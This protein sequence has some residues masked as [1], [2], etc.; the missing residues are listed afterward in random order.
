MSALGDFDS[1]SSH[2]Q[3]Q[4]KHCSLSH[5]STYLKVAQHYAAEVRNQNPANL[6]SRPY[7][8]WVLAK[9]R[10]QQSKKP[11]AG[12]LALLEHLRKL[13]GETIWRYGMFPFRHLTV[14]VP[15]ADEA[16]DWK[17]E[18]FVSEE[19][20]E[21]TRMVHRVATELGDIQLQAACLQLMIYSAS[22]PN[23]HLDALGNLWLSVGNHDG[24][25]RSKLYCYILKGS[26]AAR[27]K[28]FH[29]ILCAREPWDAELLEIQLEIL[30]ALSQGMQQEGTPDHTG[31]PDLETQS[32]YEVSDTKYSSEGSEND[33]DAFP[34][35]SYSP[36]KFRRNEMGRTP[37]REA[38]TRQW[39]HDV[40]KA[41]NEI[42]SSRFETKSG[43]ET[44]T[45]KKFGPSE[46]Q[47]K[48]KGVMPTRNYGTN[49]GKVAHDINHDNNHKQTVGS[50]HEHTPGEV[51]EKDE[52]KHKSV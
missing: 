45:K 10:L 22:D 6:K 42:S 9:F 28:L 32:N 41:K 8:Q 33:W 50:S 47:A 7:L 15:R 30:G 24:Y 16:P 1:L 38:T 11:A 26:A 17:L 25:I 12:H 51:T 35:A 49:R 4:D 19:E 29:E 13:P 5:A 21:A 27:K 34:E 43:E 3:S 20:H 23:D 44:V 14:Y 46:F 31:Y 40:S 2:I 52:G 36:G 39:L 37:D 18:S 48:K